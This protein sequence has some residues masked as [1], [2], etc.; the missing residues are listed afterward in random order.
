VAFTSRAADISGWDLN[1]ASDVF[2]RDVQGGTSV[3]ASVSM[4]PTLAGN[5]ASSSP[6]LSGDGRY[7]L[8]HSKATDLTPGIGTSADN[9][10][11]RD[12]QSG[13]TR[14]FT[15]NNAAGGSAAAMTPDGR[16]V[17]VTFFNAAGVYVYDTQT[18]QRVY[19]NNVSGANSIG[20]SPNGAR[21]AY[22]NS[23][24]FWVGDLTAHTNGLLGGALGTSRP[25][26]R[27]S[28]DARFVVYAATNSFAAVDTNKIADVYIY[29][30]LSG[31]NKLASHSFYSGGAGNDA[32]DSPDISADGRFVTYRS[33]AS[34]SW[35][36]AGELQFPCRG[37]RSLVDFRRLRPRGAGFGRL[38]RRHREVS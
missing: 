22:A 32:S 21:V 26:I 6:V 16:Y 12:L 9:I 17:A 27:F 5:S 30:F 3:L 13:I 28:A 34:D 37:R 31:T 36:S 29:D 7:V 15:T 11:V 35:I 2:V 8:F 4:S 1:G 18:S 33:R 10:Y 25:G 23:S 20:I 14:A 38:L 19:S 24:Q